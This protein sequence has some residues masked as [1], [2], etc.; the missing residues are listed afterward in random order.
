MAK[1]NPRRSSSE[2]LRLITECRQSGMPDNAWC[3]QRDIP[4]SSF[5]NA[6]TRLRKEAC[7]ISKSAALSCGTYALDFTS[8]QDVVRVNICLDPETATSCTDMPGAVATPDRLYTIE[9]M[10]S[11]ITVK[12]SNSVDTG[13]LAVV[14]RLLKGQPC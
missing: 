4:V 5:Y 3:E 9:L 14:F 11:G 2:W 8:R 7:A 13:L 12:L 10:T 6:V 1:Y